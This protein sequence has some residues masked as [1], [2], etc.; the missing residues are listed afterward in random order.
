MWGIVH[1]LGRAKKRLGY[2][3]GTKYGGSAK[4]F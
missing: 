2:A 1:G 3:Y 4:A